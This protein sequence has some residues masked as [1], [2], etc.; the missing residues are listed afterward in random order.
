MTGSMVS[1]LD[2][3]AL[4]R[5]TAT[6]RAVLQAIAAGG[7]TKEIAMAR[8]RSVKTI[9]AQRITLYR[10]LGLR[11]AVDLARFAIRTG[12]VAA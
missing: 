10:K 12:L 4:T 5:L 7:T 8:G 2:A 11:S 6:E 3:H 1:M 9:E